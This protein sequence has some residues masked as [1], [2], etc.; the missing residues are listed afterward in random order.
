VPVLVALCQWACVAGYDSRYFEAQRTQ[1]QLASD[2][3]PAG[4]SA[5][6]SP[7]APPRAM[8]TLRMRIHADAQYQS[9]IVNVP[10]QLADL[11]EDAN[12]I[13]EP[14]L[15]THIEIERIESWTSQA[16]ERADA[17]LRA[18]VA[19]DSGDGV[20]LVAGMVGA[21]PI[22]T[23][24]LHLLGMASVLGK[25]LVVR[26]PGLLGE[27]AAIDET[28]SKLSD[29]ERANI[30]RSRKRHRALAVFLHE[31][32][33]CF[34]ALHESD[35]T[36]VMNTSYRT[37][38][39]GFDAGSIA[40]MRAALDAPDRAHAAA[41]QIAILEGPTADTWASDDRSSAIASLRAQAQP[42]TAT[43]SAT[44]SAT[45]T[46]PAS[47]GVPAVPA[48]LTGDASAR[49]SSALDSLHAGAVAVAYQTA[50]PLFASYPNV[51]GVQ[52]LRCQLA[53]I[54]WLS[55]AELRAECAP[56]KRLS[57][58]PDAGPAS[59]RH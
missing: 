12:R 1:K 59:A 20:D 16:D 34:G 51:L 40:L 54:R 37:S 14:A 5:S 6:A 23:D 24:S 27:H 11:V 35:A 33:H 46:A 42:P 56:L 9:Q 32:G 2:V 7:A 21:L 18:L 36:S 38:E 48:E 58:S 49:F 53:T 19:E 39:T 3:T 43:A 4:I 52:D 30:E 31:I 41:A 44:A 22:E 45:V 10:K 57:P 55:P 29:D 13:L 50:K 17:A 47:G 8:R 26:A 25:H 28:F 15:A